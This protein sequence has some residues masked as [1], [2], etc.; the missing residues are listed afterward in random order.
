MN[1]HTAVIDRLRRAGEHIEVVHDLESVTTPTTRL[2]TTQPQTARR[3][4]RVLLAAACAALIT[5]GGAG[6][7]LSQ[8]NTDDSSSAADENDGAWQPPTPVPADAPPT[9]SVAPSVATPPAW[10]TD[11]QAAMRDGAPRSG[12]WVTTVIARPST[13][14]FDDPIQVSA[15]DGEYN[16]LR[17]TETIEL[18]GQTF[19]SIQI[20]AWQALLTDS[21]PTLIAEGA[22]ELTELADVLSNASITTNGPDFSVALDEIPDGYEVIV[23][24]RLLGESVLPRR[25]LA[26]QSNMLAINE[27]SDWIDPLLY[28]SGTGTDISRRTV[29]DITAWTGTSSDRVPLTFLVWSPQPGVLL[30]ITTTDNDRSIEDLIALAEQTTVIPIADWEEK[31]PR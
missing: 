23:T 11:L 25:V 8:Q 21:S 5:A 20:G 9:G 18:N 17:G 10:I 22:V 3:S 24:P 7:I 15:F 31:Y 2:R 28:A 1:D 13:D 29:G 6:V 4:H 12:R 16:S 27:V 30:E 19:E 26:S 14:G